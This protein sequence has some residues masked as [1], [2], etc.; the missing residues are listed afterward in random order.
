MTLTALGTLTIGGSIPGAAAGIAAGIAGINAALPDILARIAA[1]QAFAPA[2]VSFTA[3]LSLA[4]GIVANIQQ[5]ITLGLPV[6]DISAQ[7]ALVAAL[8]ADI[9]AVASGVNAN[10]TLLA[11]LQS[12]LLG[13][14]IVAYAYDGATSAMGTELATATSAGF[15]GGTGATHANALILAT[16]DAATWTSMGGVFKLTP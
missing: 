2:P 7:I 5:A 4:Q 13:G 11:S 8:V 3:Q 15:G 12:L 1:L 10:L 14:A 6:P 16:I 9:E